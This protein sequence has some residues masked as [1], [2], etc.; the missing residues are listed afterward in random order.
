MLRRCKTVTLL[1]CILLAIAAAPATARAQSA[2]ATAAY[3]SLILTPAGALPPHL[4]ASAI[5]IASYGYEISVRYGQ[6]PGSTSSR[7]IGVGIEFA[8][9]EERLGG[10]IGVA[11]CAACDDAIML[12]VNFSTALGGPSAPP[13]GPTL[14]ARLA[15][16]SNLGVALNG[17]FVVVA[18]TVE[19]PLLFAATIASGTT[20]PSLAIYAIPSGAHGVLTCDDECSASGF[21]FAFGAGVGLLRVGRMDATVGVNKVFIRNGETLVGVSIAWR[22]VP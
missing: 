22:S 9:G 20:G 7:N 14:T 21:R 19:L 18:T 5:P 4:T 13:R 11:E 17:D 6:R 16:S 2:D 3:L 12:G 10:V 8:L 1:T 15:G